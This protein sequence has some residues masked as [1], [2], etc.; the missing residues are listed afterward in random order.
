MHNPGCCAVALALVV[1]WTSTAIGQQAA[2]AAGRI[3]IASG[4]ASIVRQGVAL[5]AKAGELVFEADSLRTGGDGRLGVTLKDDS[6]ISLGPNSEVRL[7]RFL[8]APATDG[9]GFGLTILR[10]LLAYISGR[11]AK[12]SPDAVRLE[13]PSAILGVRG[14]H[15]VIRVDS[16]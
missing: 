8:F 2:A 11:I 13:T 10:G 3:K 4:A 7:D 15:V 1:A 9:V 5:P 12:L 14:T 6:R 16:P